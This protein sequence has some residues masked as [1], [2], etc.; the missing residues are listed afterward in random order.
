M[1]H[2]QQ[3]RVVSDSSSRRMAFVTRPEAAEIR[4]LLHAL[5]EPLGAFSIGLELFDTEMMTTADQARLKRMRIEIERASAALADIDFVLENG[6]PKET[7]PPR[8]A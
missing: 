2:E 5:R 4:R 1:G 6:H 7:R 3:L 8:Q